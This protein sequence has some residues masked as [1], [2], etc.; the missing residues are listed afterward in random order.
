MIENCEFPAGF[1]WGA[2]TAAYQI[3]GA[4]IEDGKGLSIW[5]T[6]C[7]RPG[8]VWREQSGDVACDHYHRYASDVAL[9]K[10][11]DLKAYR[12]SVSWPRVLPEGVGSVNPK[13]LD[14]YDKLVDELLRA[15]I[16]PYV[17]LYHW[18][19]PLALHERGGFLNR[20]SAQWFGDYAGLMA[21]RL[22]DRVQAWMTFNEPQVFL[23][24][25]LITGQHAP[26]QRLAWP[27]LLLGAHNVL[28]AHGA[29]IQ[30][31][32]AS[33]AKKTP[34]G[35][36]QTFSY[37][38]PATA[39]GEDLEAARQVA[40]SA[41]NRSAFC[42]ALWLD[43]MIFGRYPEDLVQVCPDEMPRIRQGDM[44]LIRQRND[45]LGVNM[46]FGRVVR[47]GLTGEPQLVAPVVG[48]PITALDWDVTPSIAY[49][50]PR[51]LYERYK[52]PMYITENGIAVRD[53]VALDGKVHDPS[54]ID[55]LT[56]H[57]R[58]LYRALAEGIPVLGYFHW[59]LLDNFEWAHGYK[60]RFGLF[61]VDYATQ[62]RIPKDSAVF[63]RNVIRSR[64]KKLFL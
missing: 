54:R 45:F 46:Y 41:S 50:A 34:I 10:S 30:A 26:G 38:V 25:G 16:A 43:P 8:T 4:A 49:Y 56:R 51:F 52:L 44:E 15:G 40:F 62:A 55:Y 19:L 6:F 23:E 20:D 21:D 64:G 13:G 24:E 58:E 35:T 14:F 2:A 3:E 29:G 32:R 36:A 31:I 18:D 42:A 28:R 61:H 59:S 48:N 7:T 22:G 17:T 63:Y 47:A 57:L 39:S 60:H 5:D 9:M 37:C 1:V 53:W 33:R 12:F 11:I 27:D